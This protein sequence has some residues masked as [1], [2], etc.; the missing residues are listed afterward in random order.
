MFKK[1][2]NIDSTFR[3]I[4]MTSLAVISGSILLCLFTVYR[5]Y[6]LVKSKNEKVYVLINGKALEAYASERKENLPVEARDQV[7]TFHYL[8]FNLPPDDK[9]IE[10]TISKALYLAD[11]SA[12]KQYDDLRE[13]NYYA[14]IISSNVNQTI[15]V[16]SV[17]L[18]MNSSPIA[19]RCY[20][21]Q[22]LTRPTSILT[23]SLV[24]SGQLREV[25]R[26][27]NNSHGLLIERWSIVENKDLSIN[28]R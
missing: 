4:R 7:K 28:P 25:S 13:G 3:Y 14:N 17:V 15:N 27:E 18:D 1:M 23:R 12:K 20:G 16:D 21:V 24:T 5:S 8:F 2:Q 10:A 11:E 26:S 6:D 19:F 9:G 22:T